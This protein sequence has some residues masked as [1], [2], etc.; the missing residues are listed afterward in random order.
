MKV[1]WGKIPSPKGK[2][3]SLKIVLADDSLTA[4]NMGKKIL[5]E[6]G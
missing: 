3:V 5:A 6:A 4:Q 1:L 2:S